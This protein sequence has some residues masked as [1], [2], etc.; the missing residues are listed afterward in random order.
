MRTFVKLTFIF[1][2]PVAVL[3]AL[4]YLV[5]PF[6]RYPLQLLP[7][8]DLPSREEKVHGYLHCTDRDFDAIILGSSRVMRL[9]AEYVDSYGY[10][11]Y[12]FG[13]ANCRAEDLYALL[14]MI[15]DK[16]PRPPRL[17]ILGMDPELFHPYRETRGELLML[18]E[19]AR[20]LQPWMIIPLSGDGPI[21]MKL[22]ESLRM[23][24]VSVWR[25]ITGQGPN[26]LN[27]IL[28]ENGNFAST[29][30][31]PRKADGV[32]LG[33]NL[34]YED[35]FNTYDRLSETR[36]ATF[37]AFLAL[38]AGHGVEVRAFITCVSPQMTDYISRYT[39]FEARMEDLRS[40][41]DGLDY[42]GFTWRDF[43]RP[44]NF[45]GLESDFLDPMHVGSANAAEIVDR[46]LG[47]P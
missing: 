33:I 17:V 8:V 47:E 20:Y 18:P 42:P 7:P 13:V 24:F 37:E 3:F 5:D 26:R 32:N 1:L 46:L 30:L 40:Y 43:S 22:S 10:R 34:R 9:D 23:S 28:P 14:A 38:A 27:R 2:L 44:E 15:L 4:Q 39:P 29:P 6:D 36:R 31:P 12:N 25:W 41:L 21:L 11:C 19:L 35:V 45:G 16:S